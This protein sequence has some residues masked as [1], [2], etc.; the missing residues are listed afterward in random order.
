M[1]RRAFLSFGG[2]LLL[3]SKLIAAISSHREP[4][5]TLS[6]DIFNEGVIEIQKY[7]NRFRSVYHDSSGFHVEM[8]ECHKRSS[9]WHTF[10][11]T[12]SRVNAAITF[13]WKPDPIAV[14]SVW[15]ISDFKLWKPSGSTNQKI[16]SLDFALSGSQ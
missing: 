5:E 16:F 9:E 15:W 6:L 12:E 11:I 13:R 14:E 2:L 4:D 1:E 8:R 7:K 3:P 10:E